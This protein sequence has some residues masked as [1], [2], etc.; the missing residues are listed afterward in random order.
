MCNAWNHSP[1]CTCGW[2][3]EGSKGGGFG[4]AL[5]DS[6][7]TKFSD[8]IRSRY[9][10]EARAF[11]NPNAKCPICNAGVF[12]Y[13]SPEG[14]RV[15]FD[16][17]GKPWP[18]HP[19]TAKLPNGPLRVEQLVT[20]R[21]E[22]KP[23]EW[24]PFICLSIHPAPLVGH[25]VFV[26]EGLY[27][28]AE[29]KI[30]CRMQGL[31]VRAPYLLKKSDTA[32][33]FFDVTTIQFVD[34]EALPIEFEATRSAMSLIPGHLRT[35][36]HVDKKQVLPTEPRSQRFVTDAENAAERAKRN[37]NKNASNR[38]LR[39]KTTPAIPTAMQLAFQRALQ[40]K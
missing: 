20:V 8:L 38:N 14:G 39:K 15:F 2:G 34:G 25:G 12:F 24:L 1:S 9:R 16:H 10:Q 29:L 37:R 40:R 22:L 26:L 28:H 33:N 30:F 4:F 13:Q 31:L 5:S 7:L 3:G 36:V 17:L 19:C 18:K 11:V 35:D 23:S 6:G 32:S 27:D 21:N